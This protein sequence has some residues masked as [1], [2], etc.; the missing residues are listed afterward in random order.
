MTPRADRVPASAWA[1][2]GVLLV[3]FVFSY[4]DRTALALV[5]GPIKASL[6][7][8]DVQIGLLNGFAIASAYAL[9]GVPMG[10]L[11]DRYDRRWVLF[12]GVA[13]WGAATVACGFARSMEELFVYRM[14]VGAGEAALMP[15]A[16]SLISDRFPR[17]RLGVALSVYS[18]GGSV[19]S[20]VA[21]ILGGAFVN[22]AL[23]APYMD[24]PLL[25]PIESW[26]TVFFMTGLPGIVAALLILLFRE[27]TR[28][29]TISFG[30]GEVG[31]A[32]GM[33]AFLRRRWQI[34]I[35]FVAVFGVM[36]ICNAALVFW[37]P[38]HL[39]RYFNWS[40]AAY[41]L[42]LGITYAVAGTIGM[43]VSGWMVDRMAARGIKDAPLRYFLWALGLS[44]PF[45]I[46]ALLS[47][48]VWVYFGLIWLA[49][50]ATVNFL[51]IGSLA[52]QLTTPPHLKG[53]MAALL[54]T[55]VMTLF[56]TSVGASLP[57]LFARD[58]LHDDVRMGAAIAFT[59]AICI[60]IAFVAAIFGLRS[61]RQ[62]VTEA[63]NEALG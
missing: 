24:L 52:V 6:D 41:G 40:P 56:G 12:V 8:N 28:K 47:S 4:L 31:T 20:G 34:W 22:E 17:H 18:I 60:P 62:A 48:N 32:E 59:F 21:L 7:I 61:F 49:K 15:T 43:L 27:P 54:T 50:F 29:K 55:V 2:V 42:G 16:H 5:V 26:R 33:F 13:F 44:T 53:R 14:L 10:W 19:G 46:F 45:V 58:I 3:F 9:C 11:A 38:A 63:E 35:M 36:N 30:T 25:G 51:G 1:L 57:P 23:K 37:Q 39:E